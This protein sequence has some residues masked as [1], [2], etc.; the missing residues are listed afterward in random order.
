MEGR[1]CGRWADVLRQGRRH[2]VHALKC[3]FPLLCLLVPVQFGQSNASSLHD[4]RCRLH[5]SALIAYCK[6][7]PD[8]SSSRTFATRI[9]AI[10][11]NSKKAT[12]SFEDP[13]Y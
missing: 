2:N 7:L 4:G 8:G 12:R 13:S 3:C 10:L 1:V 5:L 9:N 6:K 11:D